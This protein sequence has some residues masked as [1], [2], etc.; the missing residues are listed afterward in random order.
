MALH[1]ALIQPEIPPNTGN[2]ARLCVATDT[3]LHLIEPLGFSID[4]AEVRRAGLDYWDDVDLW[5]HPNWFAFRD[6]ISR[7][8]CLYFSANAT[9]PLW[10]ARF[11][12]NSCLVFGSETGGM[13]ARILEK[14]PEECFQIP[15]PSARVRSLNLATAAGIV[16]YEA[17]RQLDG[18]GDRRGRR[19]HPP[20]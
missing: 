11:R 13:P 10:E 7:D 9:R 19:R 4:D 16:L 20:P 15:M 18:R 3:S 8:R 12:P 5:V 6:A 14:H 1:I 17:L 2:I